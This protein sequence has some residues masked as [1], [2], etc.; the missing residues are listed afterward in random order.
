M[1]TNVGGLIPLP[2][3]RGKFP[4]GKLAQGEIMKKL[5]VNLGSNTL[6]SDG[7]GI[8]SEAVEKFGGDR[9]VIILALENDRL[10]K[11][12]QLPS[13]VEVVEVKGDGS[14]MTNVVVTDE[15][16]LVLN[17][18]M[19]PQQA[20][21]LVHLSN[22][23]MVGTVVNMQRDDCVR[24]SPRGS[25]PKISIGFPLYNC[26]SCGDGHDFAVDS[27][28]VATCRIGD[29]I[30]PLVT[31]DQL[32]RVMYR[33]GFC[34]NTLLFSNYFDEQH[35]PWTGTKCGPRKFAII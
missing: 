23:C 24:I 3:V 1:T 4:T 18:G 7:S 25:G 26:P 16:V 31:Q 10:L 9:Q 14:P 2:L 20:C 19:S 32:D 33:C 11:E 8:L 21:M 6:R 12:V 13:G 15:D 22:G 27:M 29:E 17:G 28:E 30:V 35:A 34:E 5:F